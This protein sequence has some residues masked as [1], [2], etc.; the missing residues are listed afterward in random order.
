MKAG[1]RPNDYEMET[2]TRVTYLSKPSARIRS[3]VAE[4]TGFGTLMQSVSAEKYKGRRLRLMAYVKAEGVKAWTGLWMRID[5]EDRRMLGFDNMHDRGISGTRDWAKYEVVL[6]VPDAAQGV[7]FGVM[8]V[9]TGT[10]WISNVKLEVV[11]AD[12]ATTGGSLQGPT[13]LDFSR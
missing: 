3:M 10:V 9:G 4:T 2:D 1:S 8:L 6:D 11:S 13:N 5:G 7:A 12:V